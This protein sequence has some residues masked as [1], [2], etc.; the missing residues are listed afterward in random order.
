MVGCLQSNYVF[1]LYFPFLAL[2]L[3]VCGLI[4]FTSFFFFAR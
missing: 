2:L 3:L 1:K 4:A